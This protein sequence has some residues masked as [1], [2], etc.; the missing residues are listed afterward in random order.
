MGIKAVAVI[1]KVDGYVVMLLQ[2]S[3]TSR[4]VT[5]ATCRN[6]DSCLIVVTPA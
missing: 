2:G 6:S 1:V 3:I 5:G 4:G